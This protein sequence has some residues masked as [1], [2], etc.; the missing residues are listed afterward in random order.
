MQNY[1]SIFS[2]L[3]IS[4]VTSVFTFSYS[5]S[6]STTDKTTIAWHTW[7]EAIE[8]TNKNPKKIF[9]DVYTDWCGWC[10]RM[11]KTTFTDPEI[12][13]Y[14]ND[15]FYPVKFNAE[16]KEPV[17]YK[18]HELKFV[19]SG[20]RGYHELASALLDGRMS[21]PSVVYLDKDQN[22]ITI[23]PGYKDV[24]GMIKELKFIGEEIYKE[25]TFDQYSKQ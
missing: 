22:R 11:D 2:I 7:E 4:G 14:I 15:N 23:S 12:I 10:K 1:L 16:Q 6:K 3:L 5:P 21:Y 25:L 13:K 9:V 18:G 17:Q 8:L 24:S 20:R 19:Q